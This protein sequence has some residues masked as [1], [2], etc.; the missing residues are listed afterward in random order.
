M[1]T[2]AC[3]LPGV[4][5]GVALAGSKFWAS[6]PAQNW[7]QLLKIAQ[8]CSVCFPAWR[9]HRLF[10]IPSEPGLGV[11]GRTAKL[12]WLQC[13][14]SPQVSIT[15]WPLGEDANLSAADGALPTYREWQKGRYLT[16]NTG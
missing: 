3:L 7:V 2:E 11:G 9:G 16:Q 12:G 13:P 15:V 5:P 10:L 1:G 8:L 14:S 4:L 6:E